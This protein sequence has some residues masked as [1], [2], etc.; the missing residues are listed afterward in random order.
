MPKF[1][2]CTAISLLSFAL[3]A[4]APATGPSTMPQTSPLPTRF[5]QNLIAGRA[6]SVVVYGTSLTASAEWPKVFQTYLA[7]AFPGQITFHNGAQN[8]QTSN[9][10]L[11]HLKANVL[12]H[13]PDLVFIEFSVNDSATK[14]H[15][16]LEQSEQNLDRMIQQ[17]KQQNPQADIVLMTMNLAWDA[18]NEPSGKKFATDRP[19]LGDY[20]DVYRRYAT[21]HALPLIDHTATWA[22]LKQSDE[23][24]YQSAVPDGIHPDAQ[25]SLKYTWPAIEAMLDRA[26]AAAK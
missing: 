12:D 10:G 8:G 4:A 17:I 2:A 5:F 3:L 19:H 6:Q 22:A 14:H 21:A 15:I 16:S 7:R 11:E 9:W 25:A 24:A 18:P 26:R 1:S 20:Y 23:K 13:K